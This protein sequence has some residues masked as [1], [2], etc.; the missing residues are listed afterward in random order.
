M[1]PE[2]PSEGAPLVYRTGGI[3][4]LQVALFD[5]VVAARGES[6]NIP[7]L[8]VEVFAHADHADSLCTAR[9]HDVVFMDFSMGAGHVDGAAAVKALRTSGF[10]GRVVA[11]SSDPTANAAMLAVG[12]NEALATKAHLRSFL[13]HIG[14]EHL[15]R[16]RGV[17]RQCELG[18]IADGLW[19]RALRWRRLRAWQRLP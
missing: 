14:A 8:K 2:P 16:A 15:A 6:F 7:G 18:M 19:W 4:P 9:P 10:A 13:V 1:T 17:Q 11:I 12:A 3:E 5:D